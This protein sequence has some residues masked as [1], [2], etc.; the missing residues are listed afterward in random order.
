[1]I[2]SKNH[3]T[4]QNSSPGR[5]AVSISRGGN[6]VLLEFIKQNWALILISVAF[7]ILLKSTDLQD[8]S[9]AKRMYFL[10]AGV[11]LLSI[12]VFTEFYL[13]DIGGYIMPRTVLMAVRYSATPII[14][15]MILFALQKKM[16]W[17]VFIPALILIAIN[18]ISIFN[19]IVF[20]LD[21]E[22]TLRRGPLGYL[23]Y[24]VTGLYGAVLIFILY[25]NSN[26]QYTDIIP[27]AFLGFAFA[28]GLIM[29]FVFGKQFAAEYF[30]VMILIALL[31]YVVIS[32]KIRQYRE[33]HEHDN[34]MIRESIETFTG[35]IDAKDPY[36]NGHSNRV[37]RYSRLI[38]E[39]MGYEGEELDRIYYIALL[40][41]CGKIGIPDSILSKPEK[42]TDEEYQVI[43]SHTVQGGEILNH[44]KSLEGVNEGA[45]YHHE[46]YDGKGYPKGLA[47]EEIPLIARII[48][49]ADSF[50]TMN[51]NRVYRKK[52]TKECI[53]SEIEQ[54]KGRQF[55]P[56]IADIMLKLLRSSNSLFDL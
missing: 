40:H 22:G 7:V 48:C 10:I 17:F 3:V 23:P 47:G 38:A 5:Q 45:L 13:A 39:K 37:A 26:R 29:P 24:I 41:D 11:F 2:K 43:K 16:R 51:S 19:G 1:M 6:A 53:I 18:I 33:Q 52:L 27:I 20:S 42:L 30:C 4:V 32:V 14:V 35:F 28:S 50:D 34:K 55:D 15:A 36:T 12:A 31:I 46:R 21:N 9:F 49:V 56:E 8:K 44:F 25:R 54:N